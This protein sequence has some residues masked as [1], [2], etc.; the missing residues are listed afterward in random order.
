MEELWDIYNGL[1]QK[2][3]QTIKRC[4]VGLLKDGQYHACVNAFIRNQMGNFLVQQRSFSKK[5]RPGSWDLFTGGS[6]LSGETPEEGMVREIQEE[7]SL[8]DLELGYLGFDVR[9]D[10]HCIM[11]YYDAELSDEQIRQ[12]VIQTSELETIAWWPIEDV[13]DLADKNPYDAKWLRKLLKPSP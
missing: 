6:L 12:I 3:G 5:D 10:I 8:T 1:N 2:T 9:P 4:D 11:H 13:Q 7:L